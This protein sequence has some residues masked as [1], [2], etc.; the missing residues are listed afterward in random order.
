MCVGLASDQRRKNRELAGLALACMLFAG[1][2][3]QVGCGSSSSS[4][5]GSRGTPAGT[6]TITITGTY[7]SGSLVHSTPT[8]LTVQ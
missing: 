3:F 8:K 6:Y 4:G 1:L 5:G 2:V 7:S